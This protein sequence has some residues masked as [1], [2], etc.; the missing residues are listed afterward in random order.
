MCLILIVSPDPAVVGLGRA[1]VVSRTAL[2][3][4]VPVPLFVVGAM[5]FVTSVQDVYDD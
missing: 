2:L 3:V 4:C 1:R 5:Y